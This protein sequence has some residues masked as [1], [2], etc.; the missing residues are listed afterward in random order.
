L[1]MRR[2]ELYEEHCSKRKNQFPV[3][4]YV[5][6]WYLQLFFKESSINHD[7]YFEIKQK[8]EVLTLREKYC[9]RRNT[10]VYYI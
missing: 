3:F 2:E 6:R 10:Q 9:K 8:D 1:E 4:H 7:G 5:V